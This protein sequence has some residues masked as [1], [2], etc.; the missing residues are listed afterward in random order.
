MRKRW[1]LLNGVVGLVALLGGGWLLYRHLYPIPQSWVGVWE[2]ETKLLDAGP[3]EVRLVISRRGV[4]DIQLDREKYTWWGADQLHM[5]ARGDIAEVWVDPDR[6]VKFR[7]EMREDRMTVS[8]LDRLA[9]P[10]DMM[11]FR[12]VLTP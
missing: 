6:P 3:G 12:K 5:R 8:V 4:I 1:W 7:I 9:D 2:N 11:V 10:N